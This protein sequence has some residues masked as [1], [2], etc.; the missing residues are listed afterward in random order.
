MVNVSKLATDGQLDHLFTALAHPKRRSMVHALSLRPATVAQLAG[1]NKLSL[2]AMHK[3]VQLLERAALIQRKKVGR[4][5]FVALNR[6]SLQVIKDWANQYHTEW[7]NNEESLE[8]Y[9]AR[10]R[11]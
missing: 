1:D 8:N 2:P 7:G 6:S 10:M 4:V 3:H 11:S 5:N 9:I